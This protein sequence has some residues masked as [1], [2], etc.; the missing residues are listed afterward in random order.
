MG[1]GA[2]R[3]DRL[4]EASEGTMPLKTMTAIA[5]A[6]LMSIAAVAHVI[7]QDVPEFMAGDT[8]VA[9]A[10]P[11][12]ALAARKA[13]MKE[14]GGILKGAGALTGPEAVAAMQKLYTNY[15]HIPALFPEGSIVGDSKALPIIWEQWDAFIAIPEKGKVA[16]LEA[17]TAAEAGDAAA[18]EA[19]LKAIGGTCGECHGTYRAK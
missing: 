3:R 7:G 10:T 5:I 6:G 9:P 19:A 16:M 4:I 15:S 14:D 8:F 12:E 17:I 1:V 11:E 2:A 13:L 18:Y